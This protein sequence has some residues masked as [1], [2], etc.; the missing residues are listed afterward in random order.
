MPATAISDLSLST[1]RTSIREK[2]LNIFVSPTDVFDEVIAS[3]TNLA[4]WRV[5][6][7]LVCLTGIISLQ[8]GNHHDQLAA[9]IRQ[10]AEANTISTAQ[11]QALTGLWPLLSS[12][13]VCLAAFGG[14]CWS[15]F[16]LWFIGRAFLKVRFSYLK[17][18][19]IVGLTTIILVLGS[20]VTLLL[21]VASGNPAAQPALSLFARNFSPSRPLHQILATLNV[22]HLW[23]TTVLTIGLSRLSNVSF[24]EAA[25]WVFGYWL[26]ARLVL[27]VVQ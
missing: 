6:T 2:L 7:L 18:L 4:N 16:V 10:L 25:F 23:I 5:P 8:T 9:A 3:P 20:I 27:I 12:L 24:K 26:A 17:A 19:E 13:L 11:A 21:T 14:S 22:F 1:A 15:A